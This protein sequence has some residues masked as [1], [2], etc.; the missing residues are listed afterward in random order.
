MLRL[1][2]AWCGT[3][4][5]SVPPFFVP[6]QLKCA[7]ISPHAS[8]GLVEL[9]TSST[10]LAIKRHC[11]R[12][13]CPSHVRIARSYITVFLLKI[14]TSP[15]SPVLKDLYETSHFRAEQQFN[16]Y[17]IETQK[18]LLFVSWL[19]RALIFYLHAFLLFF[20]IFVHLQP[21]RKPLF[22]TI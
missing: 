12:A 20:F 10:R 8:S 4:H 7:S 19:D 22:D 14:I 5:L 2:G 21:L 3:L 18:Y 6:G 11:F 15:S 9:G 1:A 13:G 16:S 17:T